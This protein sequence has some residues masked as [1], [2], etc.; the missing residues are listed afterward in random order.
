MPGKISYLRRVL[1]HV[2]K[3]YLWTVG[4]LFFP[5]FVIAI[6]MAIVDIVKY[7]TSPLEKPFHEQLKKARLL[8][9]QSVHL[10]EITPFDWEKV[11][12]V[13]PYVPTEAVSDLLGGQYKVMPVNNMDD[14]IYHLVFALPDKYAQPVRVSRQFFMANEKRG[15]MT[16]SEAKKFPIDIIENN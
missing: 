3:I 8:K 1:F 4:V 10:T 14:G 2:W 6:A 5:F 9:Y 12:F 16:H 11:C 15:C 7:P 13:G